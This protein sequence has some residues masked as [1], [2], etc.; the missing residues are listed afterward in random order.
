MQAVPSFPEDFL[1]CFWRD[2]L[3][4]LFLIPAL[5]TLNGVCIVPMKLFTLLDICMF[6]FAIKLVIF[7]RQTINT[8]ISFKTNIQ[9]SFPFHLISQATHLFKVS[10]SEVLKPLNQQYNNPQYNNQQY[11]K[12]Y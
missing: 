8:F 1:I 12:A 9:I 10:S 6:I 3:S 5:E 7:L 4:A 2:Y 11:S